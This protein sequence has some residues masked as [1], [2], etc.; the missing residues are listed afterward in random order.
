VLGAG[1]GELTSETYTGD[2]DDSTGHCSRPLAVTKHQLAVIQIDAGLLTL[3]MPSGDAL[4]AAYR[5]PG[6]FR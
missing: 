3:T 4:H 1:S 5:N 2:V 6:V